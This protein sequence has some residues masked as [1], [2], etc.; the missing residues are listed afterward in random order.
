MEGIIFQPRAVSTMTRRYPVNNPDAAEASRQSWKR[1]TWLLVS[2]ECRK[3]GYYPDTDA[4]DGKGLLRESAYPALYRTVASIGHT[5][6]AYCSQHSAH[7]G[8]I[9]AIPVLGLRH[10]VVTIRWAT[11]KQYERQ[12]RIADST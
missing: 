10:G 1:F 5:L 4:Y 6:H 7:Y 3:R 2:K 9:D 12:Q 11:A 8:P